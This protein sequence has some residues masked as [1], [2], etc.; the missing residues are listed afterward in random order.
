MAPSSSSAATTV[1]QISGCSSRQRV[2][3]TYRLPSGPGT[4]ETPAS[5]ADATTG[6]EAGTVGTLDGV[7][8]AGPKEDDGSGLSVTVGVVV[9]DGADAESRVG[10]FAAVPPHPATRATTARRAT[11]W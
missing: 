3:A 4:I 6:N 2:T 8:V 9:G 7:G 11:M 10:G 5:W 1:V